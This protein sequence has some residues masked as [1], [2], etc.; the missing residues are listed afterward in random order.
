MAEKE[1][2]SIPYEFDLIHSNDDPDSNFIQGS[3]LEPHYPIAFTQSTSD[4]ISFFI[5]GTEY[6]LDFSQ[7]F[8]YARGEVEGQTNE[9]VT[10]ASPEYK[11]AAA[12]DN[13]KVGQNF[14]HSLFSSV[15]V[16]INDTAVSMES[17]NYPYIAYIQEKTNFSSDQT[18]TIGACS[19]FMSTD[20]GAKTGK[21]YMLSATNEIAGVFKLKSPIFS[22]K[23][24][25]YSFM[26]VSITLNRVSNPQFYFK[27]GANCPDGYKF[28]I[29]EI[30][31][32]VRKQKVKDSYTEYLESILATGKFLRYYF[33]ECR[34]FTKQYSGFGTE[35][36][37]DDMFH[38]VQPMF[39]MFGF[40]E[41][42]AYSGAKDKDPFKFA[43]VGNAIR[44]VCLYVN[45]LPYPRSALK[46]DFETKNTF[47]A[48]FALMTAFRGT[49]NPDPPMI[50]KEEFDTGKATLFAFNLAVDQNETS[51]ALSSFNQ[52]ASLRLHVKFKQTTVSSTNYTMIVL[53]EMRSVMS[54]NKSRQVLYQAR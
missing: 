30:V 27:W 19:L 5:R 29:K 14:W 34:I 7:H 28:K 11:R 13:F 49:E 42:T 12:D 45:G 20:D 18:K 54:F 50:T 38:G 9:K 31:L 32:Y 21:D 44:E 6:W 35:L 37:E 17:S 53:Y 10:D 16:V 41:S 25:L 2:E 3:V 8:I 36:I 43:T 51:N 39:M 47:E 40:V 1:Y 33:K 24:N 23:K 52:P 15:N 46:M 26:N 4:P 48:Y 22:R